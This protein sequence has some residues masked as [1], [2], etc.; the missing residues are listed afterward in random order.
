MF[1]G[2]LALVAVARGEV[3]IDPVSQYLGDGDELTELE[4]SLH[5][6]RSI[7][8]RDFVKQVVREKLR[9][10][11]KQDGIDAHTIRK[12]QKA[13]EYLNRL[14][15]LVTTYKIPQVNTRSRMNLLKA[16]MQPPGAPMPKRPKKPRALRKG[17]PRAQAGR[18]QR[19][20][21]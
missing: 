17:R 9:H 14:Y 4:K 19:R 18:A 20:E 13:R 6:A 11:L 3:P 8:L 15:E 10:E 5:M 16:L 21:L 2:F 1:V 7:Q 12:A